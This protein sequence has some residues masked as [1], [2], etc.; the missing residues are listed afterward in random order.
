[1]EKGMYACKPPSLEKLITIHNL[2]RKNVVKCG[3]LKPRYIQEIV[4][5]SFPL[6]SITEQQILQLGG[7]LWSW[8]I[9]DGCKQSRSCKSTDCS[10]QRLERL[11]RYFG[12]Y[13]DLTAGY[14]PEDTPGT[15]AA[16]ESHEDLFAIIKG[17]KEQ[18]DKKRCELEQSLLGARPG[19]L[20]PSMKDRERAINMAVR[21]MTM[22]N[23]SS[24]RQS[25]N[26]LE[27]GYSRIKWNQDMT[28]EAFVAASLPRTDNPSL[29]EDTDGLFDMKPTLIAKSLQKRAGLKFIPTDDLSNHLKLDVRS[30]EL[31]VF[32]H[33]AFLKEHLRV[34]RNTSQSSSGTDAPKV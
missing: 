16:L 30:G 28:F 22:V 11:Q 19:K 1:V 21:V 32:H 31:H 14:E 9:C 17:L 4:M 2:Y 15:H 33:T 8:Q 20:P 23:C 18:P 24:Q 7:H 10:S 27:H 29:N 3:R 6:E 12:Y 13:K 34:T 25:S 26:F 5:L